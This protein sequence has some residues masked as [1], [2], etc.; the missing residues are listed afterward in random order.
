MH[1]SQ[2]EARENVCKHA[3]GGFGF[4]S[5]WMRKRPVMQ[6]QRKCEFL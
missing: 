2:C 6:I 3:A 1:R 4:T 5:D